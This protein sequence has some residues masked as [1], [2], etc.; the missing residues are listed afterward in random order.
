MNC[1]TP[2]L[3]VHHQLLEFTQTH[4]HRVSDAIQPSHPLSSPSPPAPNPSQHRGLFQWVISSHQVAKVLEF[5]LQHQ[6]FQ[7]TPRTGLLQDGLVGPPC[8]PSI[9]SLQFLHLLEKRLL[10]F[11]SEKDF[12]FSSFSTS[13]PLRLYASSYS[14]STK[15]MPT[16]SKKTSEKE[17]QSWFHISKPNLK[18]ILW[19]NG[20]TC[21]YPVFVSV[22]LPA[23][24]LQLSME[25]CIYIYS[26]I[27]IYSP[28]WNKNLVF[29]FVITFKIVFLSAV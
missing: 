21:L 16:T 29:V 6:C 3:P 22:C 25:S 23:T 19:N 2:G 24:K 13:C 4:V 18:L 9:S 12:S 7:W 8:S 27:W 28:R 15:H 17:N 5:Q 20:F 14:F 1:S 26:P 10:V 11:L